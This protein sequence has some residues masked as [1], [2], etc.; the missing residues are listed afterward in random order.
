MTI[1]LFFENLLCCEF[2]V[3]QLFHISKANELE[4]FL[5]SVRCSPIAMMS[6]E[7]AAYIGEP[8]TQ[9]EFALVVCD[10]AHRLK[11]QQGRLHR[12][13]CFRYPTGL[14]SNFVS[15]GLLLVHL[16]FKVEKISCKGEG[17][18]RSNLLFVPKSIKNFLL[19]LF[20]GFSLEYWT[21]QLN[22]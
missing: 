22:S 17:F 14:A 20:S 4:K 6:Y 9:I 19:R 1:L 15:G 18:S 13:V 21:L 10:E 2:C 12:M 3:L 5:V 16:S 7:M 11:N 8:L